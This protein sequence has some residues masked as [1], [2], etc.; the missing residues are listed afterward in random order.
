MFPI[1]D[2]PKTR[3]FPILNFL[4]I[5]AN[6][7]VFLQTF[8]VLNPNSVIAQY[9]LTPSLVNFS[10]FSTLVPFVTSL[11]LHGGFLHIIS[12]MWFLWIFGD[13]VEDEFGRWKYLVIYFG[14]GLAGN[15]LQYWLDPTSTIPILGASGAISGILAAYFVSFPHAEVKSLV[16]IFFLLTIIEIPAW[17]YILYWFGL[18]VFSGFSSLT[19]VQSGGVAFWAHVGGFVIGIILAKLL[20]PRNKEYI[21]G[22][23]VD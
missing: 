22:E 5:G 7:I 12:N 2:S 11:F 8:F 15:L 10:S 13:N 21:E 9:S 14:A 18:Q 16:P 1:S 23:I 17:I 6:V 4:I 20:A 19:S 3:T